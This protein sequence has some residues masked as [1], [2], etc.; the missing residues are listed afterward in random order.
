M[1]SQS[2]GKN[3][4]GMSYQGMNAGDGEKVPVWLLM[5]KSSTNAGSG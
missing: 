5:G 1:T 2:Q 4:Q 3:D